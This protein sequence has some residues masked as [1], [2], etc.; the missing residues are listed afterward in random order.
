MDKFQIRAIDLADDLEIGDQVFLELLM[1]CGKVPASSALIVICCVIKSSSAAWA[2]KPQSSIH[3]TSTTCLR[4]VI[5][6]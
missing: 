2:D 3:T 5:F 4:K 6:S 1:R